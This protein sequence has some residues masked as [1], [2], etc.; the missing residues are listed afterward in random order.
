MAWFLL[1]VFYLSLEDFFKQVNIKLGLT[2]MFFEIK[3]YL[4]SIGW[5]KIDHFID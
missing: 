3:G 2:R 5:C 1:I 4:F